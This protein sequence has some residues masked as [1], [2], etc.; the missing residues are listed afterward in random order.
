MISHRKINFD[1][2]TVI[3]YSLSQ[4]INHQ[5]IITVTEQNNTYLY[6]IH[7][8][9]CV[10]YLHFFSILKCLKDRKVKV[11]LISYQ[12]LVLLLISTPH[13]FWEVHEGPSHVVTLALFIQVLVLCL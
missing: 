12:T 7:I 9:W 10:Q 6:I 11:S 1:L 4:S 13:N 3:R 8:F 2:Q 5:S